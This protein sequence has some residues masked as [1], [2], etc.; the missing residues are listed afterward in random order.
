MARRFFP[1]GCCGAVLLMVLS[2]CGSRM[3]GAQVLAQR[4]WAGSGVTVEPWWRRAVFYR[5]DPARFQ[6]SDGDGKGDL[7]GVVQRLDYLQMLGVDALI[8]KPEV[9]DGLDDLVRSAAG[10]HV[11]VLVEMGAPASQ[12]AAE[13]ARYVA[14]ARQWL[15]QG[16][17]GLYVPT[18][19]LETVD[20]AAHIGLLLHQLRALTDS[21]P[22]GRVLMADKP[23]TPDIGLL[24]ALAKETQLSATQLTGTTA[25]ELRAELRGAMGEGEAPAAAAISS[26]AAPV[27]A[28]RRSRGRGR[29]AAAVAA[30]RASAA[31]GRTSAAVG[32]TGAAVGRTGAEPG[33][34]LAAARVPEGVQGEARAGLER[35]LAV[36][37]LASR[38]AVVLEYGQELGLDAAAG[39]VAGTATAKAVGPLMQ[40]T[41]SNVTRAVKTE[42]EKEAEARAAAAA[43]ATQPVDQ[44][45][46]AYIRPLRKDFFPPPRMPVVVESDDVVPVRVDPET[47][48]GFTSGRLDTALMAANGA[49]AN[50]ALEQ[51]NPA[52]LWNLYRQ[53]IELHHENATVR[54]GAQMVMDYD[55]LDAVVWERRAP[56]SSRTSA[57][58]VAACNLSDKPVVLGSRVVRS[59]LRP[60]GD[61]REVAAGAVL[62]GE[63]R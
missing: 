50:V 42:A 12:A 35:A 48:P 2:V 57:N 25:R 36:I 17:A 58:V 51:A 1:L 11:R 54:N 23:S 13:D 60:Q 37:L 28:A 39:P 34:L 27:K 10:S 30:P 40:W 22:G 38:S 31:V 3:A 26:A 52:S 49:V 16:A 21:F 32:R 19:L 8:V 9:P 20:G 15:N 14:Q 63:T 56:A 5:I 55:A 7:A 62:V 29:R 53:L 61:V 41:P 18:R 24:N 4:N 44:T 33:V 43:K 46:H 45:F 59:L 47:L 6:D